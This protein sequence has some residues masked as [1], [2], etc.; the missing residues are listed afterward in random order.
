MVLNNEKQYATSEKSARYTQMKDIQEEQR[1]LYE[2]WKRKLIPLIAEVFPSDDEKTIEKLAMENARYM[3]SVFTPTKMLHTINIRQ[4]NFLLYEFER[5]FEEKKDSKKLFERKIAEAMREFSDKLSQFR[6]ENLENRTDRHLSLFSYEEFPE[7]F[8]DIYSTNYLMSF[9]GLA[10]AQRHRTISY[11]IETPEEKA[12]LGFFVPEIV[13][14]GGLEEEW[15]EDLEKVAQNDFPQAQLVSVRERGR[16]EDF[17][18]KCI[19]RLC[20][21]AQYEIMKNTLETARKY[22]EKIPKVRDWISA[23][24]LQSFKCNNP[25]AWGGKKALER[26]V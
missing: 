16:L 1:K 14:F 11:D 23:P 22:S 5:Y 19:L 9:A 18:S 6:I 3:T 12:P 8:S 20:G 2:K 15:I 26:I 13:K 10:Q 24:C 17:R 25:C 7:H 4:L 21:H